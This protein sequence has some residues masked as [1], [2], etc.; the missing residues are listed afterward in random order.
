MEDDSSD[1]YRLNVQAG[2]RY[3]VVMTTLQTSRGAPAAA[4]SGPY[5]DLYLFPMLT[6]PEGFDQPFDEPDLGPLQ[7]GAETV[8][9]LDDSV[10]PNPAFVYA[11]AEF[12]ALPTISFDY[13]GNDEEPAVWHAFPSSPDSNVVYFYSMTLTD[14]T[15]L[16]DESE[17]GYYTTTGTVEVGGSVTGEIDVAHDA[18]WFRVELKAGTTYRIRMRGAESD[19][20]TLADPYLRGKRG[21][22]TFGI[23]Q[24]PSNDDKNG[25][26]KDSEITW[27]PQFNG[28]YFI[29]ANTKTSGTGTY[30]IE[31]EVVTGGV[32]ISGTARQGETLT[33]DT[34]MIA[35]P[36]GVTGA[37]YT[38]QWVRVTGSLFGAIE[39]NIPGATGSAYVLVG[40][41]VGNELKV[42][43]TYTDDA[44]NEETRISNVSDKVRPR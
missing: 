8:G 1:V 9:Q 20:R 21:L 2:R 6:S 30:T 22:D 29:E 44:G 41:D 34:S 3:R 33:A 38:F 37:S 15:D 31:V 28:D 10:Q 14:I 24:P 16:E 12:T 4:G 18:D 40:E 13:W 17:L 32:R 23:G 19:G 39:E 43:V 5:L 7:A 42:R 11:T 25:T 27:S 35:D 36:D 26:G